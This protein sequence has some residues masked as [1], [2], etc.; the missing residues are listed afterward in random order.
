MNWDKVS[1]GILIMVSL[2]TTALP[3][4]ASPYH[5]SDNGYGR[6]KVVD[7]VDVNVN[8]GGQKKQRVNKNDFKEVCVNK[9]VRVRGGVRTVRECKLVRVRR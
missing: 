5:S 1:T 4:S 8:L 7:V 2:A 9:R 6:N 3:V